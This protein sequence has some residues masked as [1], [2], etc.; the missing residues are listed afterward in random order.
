MRHAWLLQKSTWSV[1]YYLHAYK[2]F[3]LNAAQFQTCIPQHNAAGRED[4]ARYQTSA[5]TNKTAGD[6]S[7]GITTNKIN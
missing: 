4:G 1:L 7:R 3:R 6:I 5:A 2:G